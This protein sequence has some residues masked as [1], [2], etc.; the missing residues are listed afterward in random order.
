MIRSRPLRGVALASVSLAALTAAGAA[1]DTTV[2]FAPY[3]QP[4]DAGPLGAHDQIVV[5]WQTN[6]TTPHPGAYQVRFG[7]GDRVEASAQVEGRV[8]DNYLAA[9]PAVPVPPTSYGA[10]VDYVA[11]LRNLKFDSVYSY[12]VTGPG[13]PAGGFTAQFPTR[14]TGNHF[15][16][17]VMGDEGDFNGAAGTTLLADYEARIVHL[18]YNAGNISLPGQPPRPQSEFN[19]VTGDNVYLTGA[20]DSYRDFWMPVWNSDVDSADRGAP[21]IRKFKN[22]IVIG[23]H[24]MGL[25]GVSVNLLG[26]AGAV[27][28]FS[29]QT[30]GGDA[31]SFFNNMYYP[32]NGPQGVDIYSVFNGDTSTDTGAFFQ[33][34][35]ANFT[36]PKAAEALRASTLA[37]TGS[38][39]K[40]QI[41]H[42]S[43]YSFDYGNIHFV[44]LDSNPHLFNGI[45]SG[46]D[47]P[48]AT[49]QEAFPPYPSVLR[50]WLIKDLDS[51]D[52]PWKIVVYH[53]PGY[54]SGYTTLRDNQMRQITQVLQDHGVNIVY[55]GHEHNYQRTRPLRATPTSTVP[56]LS[57]LPVAVEMDTR[58]DGL[59]RQVPDGILHIINGAG[60]AT[61]HDV[62]EAA[63]RGAAVGLDEEDTATG[64]FVSNGVAYP[65]GPGAWLDTHLTVA[66]GKPFDTNAGNGPKITVVFKGKVFSFGQ[67]VVEGNKLTH[68]QIS[69]PLKSTSSATTIEPFPFGKDFAGHPI[70]DPMADTLVDPATGAVVGTNPEGTPDLLD[71]WSIEKPDLSDSVSVRLA[72]QALGNSMQSVVITNTSPYGLNG[73]QLVLKVGH[74][75]GP[76]DDTHSVVPG[77]VVISLGRV[78]PGAT[79]TI[80]LPGE[81]AVQGVLRSATALP[82]AIGDGDDHHGPGH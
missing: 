29:G 51:S 80:E 63:P 27:A 40:R 5:T 58:F 46:G 14:N 34:N 44:L 77:G 16:F 28:Q 4:G 42:A 54:N 59:T 1:A 25:T 50:E 66:E 53:H 13:M 38:G 76:V 21:F 22:Y 73:A 37:D 7:E 20:E 61:Q 41:D 19:I 3:V 10:H 82:V 70:N 33:L 75:S 23:N 69:E 8:V 79:T 60:G 30:G 64:T 11:V 45:G 24:D 12:Q 49:P 36:S 47:P 68:Y 48:D 43:N 6:E 65:Q 57:S 31:L 67:V 2:T 9:D 18:L 72:P 52:Q 74:Y 56:P 17:T 81:G 55:N 15:S 32:S 26:T 35:G 39:P 62:D 78:A 71:K